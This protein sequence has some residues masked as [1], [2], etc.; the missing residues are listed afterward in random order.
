MYKAYK[1]NSE[2]MASGK[3]LRM[4]LVH[5]QNRFGELCSW[6]SVQRNV[7]HSAAVI[8][9][10][11]VPEDCIILVKQFRPPVGG[12]EISFPAGLI[13]PGETA[14]ETAPRE[15]LEETGY[16][17]TL[18]NVGFPCASSGGLTGEMLYPV[19]MQVDMNDERNQVPHTDFKDGEDISTILVPM[20]ILKEYLKKQ[21]EQGFIID[22]RLMFYASALL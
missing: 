5:Y 16:V 17:G 10:R 6:E 3:F 2:V 14:E 21:Q 12:Y 13:D 20:K 15:L 8:I 18:L 19:R 9:A 4:E 11:T 1:V 7:T 22:S